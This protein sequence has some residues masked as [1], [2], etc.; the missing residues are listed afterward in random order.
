MCLTKTAGVFARR[1]Y[2]IESL[3]VGLNEDKAAFTIFVLRTD[4][5]ATSSRIT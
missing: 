3:A 4:S 1:G 5:L 2:K